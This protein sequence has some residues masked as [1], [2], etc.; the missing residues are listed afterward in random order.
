M[1]SGGRSAVNLGRNGEVRRGKK[2]RGKKG[3]KPERFPS[4]DHLS[5]AGQAPR[6]GRGEI[7]VKHDRSALRLLAVGSSGG[8]GLAF[9][10]RILLEKRG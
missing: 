5:I 6:E 10:S 3:S 1:K 9:L 8:V 4:Q 2:I 7:E